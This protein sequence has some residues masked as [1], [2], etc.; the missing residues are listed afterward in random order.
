MRGYE[1][2]QSKLLNLRSSVPQH[3]QY[4]AGKQYSSYDNVISGADDFY[5]RHD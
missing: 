4:F 2:E 5:D 1:F 3:E